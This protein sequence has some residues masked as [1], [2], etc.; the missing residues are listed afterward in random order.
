MNTFLYDDHFRLHSD[1][2]LPMTDR[3]AEVKRNRCVVGGNVTNE[4]SSW[5]HPNPLPPK[6]PLAPPVTFSP[7][8]TASPPIHPRSCAN[9][10]EAPSSEVLNERLCQLEAGKNLYTTCTVHSILCGLPT[11]M[12]TRRL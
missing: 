11:H 3:L 4:A 6:E 1:G 10:S 12:V 7:E 2:G 9:K 8:R 5:G